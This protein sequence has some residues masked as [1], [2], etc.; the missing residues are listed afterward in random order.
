[1]AVITVIGGTGYAGAA[2]VAEAHA[3]GHQVTSIS[4]TLPGAKLDGV[5]YKTADVT[6]GVPSLDGADEVVAALSPRGSNLGALPAVYREI[7]AKAAAAGARFVAIGGFRLPTP[8][9][10]RAPVRRRRDSPAG[11]V[12]SGSV[13]DERDP[14]RTPQWGH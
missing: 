14:H 7:A 10:G 12:P 8:R 1:M 11:G 2:I 13:G 9:Q 4:R 5:T 6:A 3:R